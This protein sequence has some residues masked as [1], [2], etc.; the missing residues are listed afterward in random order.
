MKMGTV[1]AC[2]VALAGAV[3]CSSALNYA[4]TATALTVG[5]DVKLRAEVDQEQHL[6]RVRVRAENLAPPG[7]LMPDGRMFVVWARANANATWNRI[8]VL[9]YDA[10]DRKGEL[11][12]TV[13]FT[14][15]E[16]MMTAESAAEAPTPSDK[17][18]IT[19]RVGS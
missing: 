2:V 8:G 7:R 10:D 4:P 6:T 15:F 12:A 1:V 11:D 5:A 18:V 3:G 14:A 9:T 16:L 13:P 17:V 19:Q